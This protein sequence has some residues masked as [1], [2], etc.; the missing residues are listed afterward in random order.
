[1][2]LPIRLQQSETPWT[3]SSTLGDAWLQHVFT[4]FM[5]IC[6][7]RAP[8]SASA[9]MIIIIIAIIILITIIITIIM[10]VIS[11]T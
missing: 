3:E 6:L 10:T 8:L 7:P 1:M 9:I 5:F 11:T 2:A 4:E